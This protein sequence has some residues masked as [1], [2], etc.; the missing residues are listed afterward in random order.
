MFTRGRDKDGLQRAW[1]GS[2]S[3]RLALLIRTKLLIC[4]MGDCLGTVVALWRRDYDKNEGLEGIERGHLGGVWRELELL[5]HVS[6][7]NGKALQSFE[8]C[9]QMNIQILNPI[10]G[11]LNVAVDS[12]K[13]KKEYLFSFKSS[14]FRATSSPSCSKIFFL[15]PKVASASSRRAPEAFACCSSWI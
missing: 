14:I 11:W 8:I 3:M 9:F 10:N 1:G 12:M 7:A 6:G 4:D 13:R 15:A 2:G 5:H